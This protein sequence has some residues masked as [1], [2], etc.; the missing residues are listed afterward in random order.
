MSETPRVLIDAHKTVNIRLARKCNKGDTHI[1]DIQT[2]IED[3]P[4]G[5]NMIFLVLTVISLM[6]N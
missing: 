1:L 6:I 2:I 3:S 4:P 5:Y